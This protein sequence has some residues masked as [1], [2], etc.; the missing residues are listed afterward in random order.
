M[1]YDCRLVR[2][3]LQPLTGASNI[4]RVGRRLLMTRIN[5]IFLGI[6]SNISQ[7]P[8]SRAWNTWWSPSFHAMYY[9]YYQES[10]ISVVRIR[11]L[12]FH[13]NLS[14]LK[15]VWSL[16]FSWFFN[17]NLNFQRLFW[18]EWSHREGALSLVLIFACCI[19]Y[20]Q[21][22]AC[23][24]RRDSPSF[25]AHRPINP[26]ETWWQTTTSLSAR[27][28]EK[29]SQTIIQFIESVIKI[30]SWYD[31][32]IEIPSSCFQS[33]AGSAQ[34]RDAWSHS[35]V[36]CFNCP[37]SYLMY[38]HLETRPGARARLE[39]KWTHRNTRQFVAHAGIS[40]K[41]FYVT[42]NN[43]FNDVKLG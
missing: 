13:L 3:K 12:T 40:E 10:K 11:H 39:W 28:L 7:S 15:P 26:P 23:C 5:S 4:I 34:W 19:W 43:L 33:I 14:N 20:L 9:I 41:C 36:F 18:C 32:L 2:C 22:R 27:K 29:G 35:W 16:G 42:R 8:L 25:L 30:S 31:I 6:S 1:N 24:L 17:S 38:R 21:S 37:G